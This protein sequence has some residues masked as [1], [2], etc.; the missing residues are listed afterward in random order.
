[1]DQKKKMAAA[2]A[3]VTAYIET[4]EAALCMQA[5]ASPSEG[6]TAPSP[7]PAGPA[8]L[9]GMSGRQTLMQMGNMM[10]LKVFHRP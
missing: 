1:M 2:I 9:W 5:A 8:N 4:E 3:A 6:A 7:A 10:Q